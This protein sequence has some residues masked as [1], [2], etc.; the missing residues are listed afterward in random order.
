MSDVNILGRN[1]A[2][3]TVP[4]AGLDTG[5]A[6]AGPAP[7]FQGQPVSTGV[8][9]GRIALAI[10]LTVWA[11]GWT[12][13]VGDRIVAQLPKPHGIVADVLGAFRAYCRF[14]W[15][16]AYLLLALGRR[17]LLKSQGSARPPRW[18]RPA[19]W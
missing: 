4:R 13:W 17:E 3:A 8:S 16:V 2:S 9:A 19:T 1:T 18:P 6:A 5:P 7:D 11:V 15:T 14:F 10:L 12:V